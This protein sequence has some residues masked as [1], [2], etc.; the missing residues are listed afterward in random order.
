MATESKYRADHAGDWGI[1]QERAE[2]GYSTDTL[3]L[4]DG[5]PLFFRSWRAAD[6]QAPVLVLL[7]GLG[8]HTGWFIDMG[9]ALQARGITVY[10]DDHRGFG[11]SGGP[12]GHVRAWRTYVEDIGEFVSAV[13]Q[14][15]PGSP[16]SLLGHSMGAVFALYV[17]AEDARSG[18]NQLAS[19]LLLNP[20]IADT[21]K[22]GL[23]TQLRIL[24]GGMRGSPT[25]Y[26]LAGGSDAMTTNAEAARMLEADPHW[27]R[28]ES[29]AFL[30]QIGLRMRGGA[31]RQA[32]DVRAP[33]L[34]LQAERDLAIVPA[35][36]RRC[37]ETLGSREK[38]WKTYAGYAHDS[39]FEADRSALDDDIAHW[40]LSHRA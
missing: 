14:W 5:T 17:A 30:Y 11:R 2:S 29:A 15:Q 10:A 16:L 40:L 34:V 38:D 6:P 37:Y 33:T 3:T 13:R 4:R 35:A 7:H 26:R 19:L 27:V 23:G 21:S 8:A 25:V 39:E 22:V 31:L 32:R 20:W 24:F 1:A 28:A 36:A 18:R 12:R 9:N